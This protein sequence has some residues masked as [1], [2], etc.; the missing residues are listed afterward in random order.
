[1]NLVEFI[2]HLKSDKKITYYM[3]EN[4]P[5]IDYYDAEVYLKGSLSIYA[6]L[7]I[8]DGEKIEGMIKMKVDNEIYYNLFSLDLLVETYNDFLNPN[9]NDFEIAESIIDYRI[10]DA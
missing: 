3:N 5:N 6:D 4:Y 9:K 10:N 1:M 2:K 8:F 7:V